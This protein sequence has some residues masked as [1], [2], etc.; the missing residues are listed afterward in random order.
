MADRALSAFSHAFSAE[1]LASLPFKNSTRAWR[2]KDVYSEAR[3]K[4]SQARS[5]SEKGR[6]FSS[7]GASARRDEKSPP[8][9]EQ[10]TPL[11]SQRR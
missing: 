7:I 8:S 3:L 10:W 6:R 9:G 5:S 1:A 2:T 11:P 4:R